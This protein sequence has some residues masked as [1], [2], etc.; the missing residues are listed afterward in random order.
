M[1]SDVDAILDKINELG[2]QSLTEEE[3]L[4]LE[5]SSRKLSK[6]VDRDS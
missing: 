3:R 4:T 2:F 5:K 6:R 1:T